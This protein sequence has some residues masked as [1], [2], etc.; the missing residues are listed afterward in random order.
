MQRNIFDSLEVYA[1]EE[2]QALPSKPVVT[3][4]ER[5]ASETELRQAYSTQVQKPNKPNQKGSKTIKSSNEDRRPHHERDLK[6]KRK[7]HHGSNEVK[8]DIKNEIEE[9]RENDEVVA[10]E[11]NTPVAIQMKSVEQYFKSQGVEIQIEQKVEQKEDNNSKKK[12]LVIPE[13]Y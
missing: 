12:R 2:K 1:P 9:T 4:R 11:N 5:K 6:D 13:S 10:Q 7:Y 8:S 3:K